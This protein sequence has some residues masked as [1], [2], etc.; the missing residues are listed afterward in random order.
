MTMFLIPYALTIEPREDVRV[1][2]DSVLED[3]IRCSEDLRN[4]DHVE[5]LLREMSDQ[6]GHQ[7]ITHSHAIADALCEISEQ[8][9]RTD[10]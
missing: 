4:T 9:S 5:R 1:C 7:I 2:D 10:N 3:I 6:I 8:I